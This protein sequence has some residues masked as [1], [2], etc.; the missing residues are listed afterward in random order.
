VNRLLESSDWYLNLLQLARYMQFVIQLQHYFCL[1]IIA[2]NL[3][4][5]KNLWYGR[6]SLVSDSAK[7]KVCSIEECELDIAGLGFS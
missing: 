2:L 7:T 6:V 1:L 4:I 3:K 5:S